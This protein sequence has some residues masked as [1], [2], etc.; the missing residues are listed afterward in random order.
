MAPVVLFGVDWTAFFATINW[1]LIVYV[2]V[3]L[4]VTVMG[5]NKLSSTGAIIATI[6]TIGVILLSIFFGYRWF[7]K[8]IISKKWPPS[9]NMCPDYLTFVPTVTSLPNGGCVDLLGVSTNGGLKKI[10][11]SV[12]TGLA[13]TNANVFNKTSK[14][15]TAAVTTASMQTICTLCKDKGVT[16]E[17]VYDG[18][19]CVGIKTIDAKNAA[20]A[21]CPI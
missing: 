17:G 14:D 20:L 3:S 16:W 7:T 10:E 1:L 21:A 4:G 19:V 2:I 6:Y 8:T 9:I 11:K 15:V 5:A 12:I 13:S 18:D